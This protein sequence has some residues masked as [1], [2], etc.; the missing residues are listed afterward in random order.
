MGKAAA[1]FFLMALLCLSGAHAQPLSPSATI[2][3]G[4]GI[5]GI[6]GIGPGFGTMAGIGP[7]GTTVGGTVDLEFDAR[8][9]QLNVPARLLPG[10]GRGNVTTGGLA[11]T[12][13]TPVHAA[14][15]TL[16]ATVASCRNAIAKAATRYGAVYV[17]AASAGATKRSGRGVTAP[18]ETR[19]VYSRNGGSQARQSLISCRLN[20]AGRVVSLS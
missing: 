9:G 16:L 1:A 8:I 18:I 15:G 17:S 3:L 7:G 4:W 14:P 11:S 10:D 6:Q 5:G 20:A 13:F 2:N 19:I 12:E